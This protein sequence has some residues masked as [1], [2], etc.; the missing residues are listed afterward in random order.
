LFSLSVNACSDI[1]TSQVL[2]VNGVVTPN[3]TQTE[4]ELIAAINDLNSRLNS[5]SALI[6]T[7]K[8]NA[9]VLKS[10]TVDTGTDIEGLKGIQQILGS[11]SPNKFIEAALL[12]NTVGAS[13]VIRMDPTGLLLLEVKDVT[14][15]LSANGVPPNIF[16][17]RL[18]IFRGVLTATQ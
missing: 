8:L 17:A 18:R 15:F 9:L 13:S 1:F 16:I 7:E 4:Q 10:L 6:G 14:N 3:P 12:M 5:L 11:N 2:I